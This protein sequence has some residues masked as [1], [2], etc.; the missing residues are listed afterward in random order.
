MSDFRAIA[1]VSSTLKRLL[2]DQME[3]PVPVTIAPP[4]ALANEAPS[5]RVNLFL[6]QVTENGYLKNQEIPGQGHPGAYGCPPLSLDL[7]YL[8]TAYAS[9]ETADLQA[10]QILGDA[11]RVLHD[12]AIITPAMHVNGD[13]NALQILDLSLIGEFERLKIT[14]QPL[15]LEDFSKIWTALPQ[16][17]FRRSVAYQVSVVQIESRRPRRFP[18]LVGEPPAAGPRVHVVPFRSPQINEI[19]VWR[20]GDPSDMERAFPYARIGDTLIIRGRNFASEATRVTLGAIDP[21]APLPPLQDDRIKTVV[22]DEVLLQPGPQAVKVVQDLMLGEPLTP[23][24]GFHSNLAVFMLVP[25]AVGLTPNLG[26][27]PQTLQVTGSRLFH[28][29][30]ECLALVGDTVIPASDYTTA[31]PTEITFN[32]P[33]SLGSGDHTIRVRVNGAES[34]DELTLNIP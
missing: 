21:V 13:P 7:H 31:T 23:H 32:L 1:G 2:E 15:N 34:I 30:L 5:N 18:R 6:Y 24:R 19:R 3:E 22:P 11:M 17:N 25:H 4:D 10:Q 28:P 29:D 8:L 27:T 12:F 16:A 14:L 9:N 33:D 20:P 26:A